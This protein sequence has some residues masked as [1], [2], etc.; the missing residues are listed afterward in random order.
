M[1]FQGNSR[2]LLIVN[3]FPCLVITSTARENSFLLVFAF[4]NCCINNLLNIC[5]YA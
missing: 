2:N 3:Y 5:T 4:T 1:E